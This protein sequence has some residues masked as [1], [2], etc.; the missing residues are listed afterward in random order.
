M[1]CIYTF[2]ATNI[3]N[4]IILA[5]STKQYMC[6]VLQNTKIHILYALFFSFVPPANSR[7]GEVG[8]GGAGKGGRGGQGGSGGRGGSGGGDMRKSAGGY[9]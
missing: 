5:A 4:A 8:E 3:Q 1:I 9:K 2:V 6:Y 7:Q